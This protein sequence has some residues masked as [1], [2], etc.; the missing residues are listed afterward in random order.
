MSK[1]SIP[2]NPQYVNGNSLS[3]DEQMFVAPAIAVCVSFILV[4]CMVCFLI[5]RCTAEQKKTV[6]YVNAMVRG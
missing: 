6:S 4:M 3:E 1:T 5:G 2:Q